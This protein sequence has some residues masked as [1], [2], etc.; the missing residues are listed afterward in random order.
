MGETNVG[1]IDSLEQRRRYAQLLLNDL[2]AIRIMQAEGMFE[3]GV[4]KIGAEQGLFVLDDDF[5]PS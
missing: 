1:S 4:Y 3:S 5:R 2:K